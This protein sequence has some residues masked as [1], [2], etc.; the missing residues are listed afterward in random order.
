MHKRNRRRAQRRSAER[1]RRNALALEAAATI[2]DEPKVT[3][4]YA[5]TC[6]MLDWLLHQTRI[7]KAQHLAGDRLYRDYRMS[8]S[9][10]RITMWWAPPSTRGGHMHD[11]TTSVRARERFERALHHAGSVGAD[12]LMH[13]VICDES[14]T[15]WCRLNGH[16][17]REGIPT[18]RQA[19]DALMQFYGVTREEAAAAAA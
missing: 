14:A 4:V 12:C 17:D 2:S 10:Q 11:T 19:L 9:E 13:V 16:A 18:L 5:R 8:G 6:R 1:A 7:S 3:R 15:S